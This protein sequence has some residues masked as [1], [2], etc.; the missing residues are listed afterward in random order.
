[1]QVL[2]EK[3]SV[4]LKLTN[5]EKCRGK[6]KK[7]KE[8]KVC[9][10]ELYTRTLSRKQ[11]KPCFLQI[12]YYKVENASYLISSRNWIDMLSVVFLVKCSGT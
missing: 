11:I 3:H 10:R 12:I 2:P 8:L 9:T 6:K 4:E 5:I 7:R 1:V